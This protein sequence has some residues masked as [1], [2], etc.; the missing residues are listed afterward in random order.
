MLPGL[1]SI[2]FRQLSPAQIVGLCVE[3]KLQVIEW[4][5]MCM[6]PMATLR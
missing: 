4:G 6:C 2:T 3:N 5:A 1:V